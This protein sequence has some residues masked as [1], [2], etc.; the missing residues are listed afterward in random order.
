MRFISGC[1]THRR[2]YCVDCA[3]ANENRNCRTLLLNEY[4]SR[5]ANERQLL[6]DKINSAMTEAYNQIHQKEQRILDCIEA[7]PRASYVT[8]MS[9]NV[10]IRV[11]GTTKFWKIKL[12]RFINQLVRKFQNSVAP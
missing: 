6:Q 5:V 4:N 11:Y 3:Y 10:D 8:D 2:D 9:V 12:R 1:L 7:D